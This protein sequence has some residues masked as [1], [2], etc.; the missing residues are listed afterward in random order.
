M[1]SVQRVHASHR[2]LGEIINKLKSHFIKDKNHLSHFVYFHAMLYNLIQLN[3]VK[4]YKIQHK[5]FR[6]STCKAR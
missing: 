2:N 4:R 6:C 1:I 3:K 5:K